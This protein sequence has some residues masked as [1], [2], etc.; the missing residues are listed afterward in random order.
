MPLLGY[1]SIGGAF[2]SNIAHDPSSITSS[3]S[4]RQAPKKPAK[5]IR[6]STACVNCRQKKIK[7]D[8]S[9]PCAHCEKLHAECVYPVAT[10]P[11][12]QEYVETL[13]N[14]LKSVESHL[15]GL[16]SRGWGKGAGGAIPGPDDDPSE[17]ND[18][19]SPYT[20]VSIPATPPSKPPSSQPSSSQAPHQESSS[21]HTHSRTHSYGHTLSQQFS[22]ASITTP[23]L[24]GTDTGS[25]TE[26]ENF[27]KDDSMEVLSLLMGSLKVERDG[28]AQYLPKIIDQQ[29]RSY[30]DSRVY[31]TSPSSFSDMAALDW[32][33]ADHPPSYT[34]PRTLLTPKAI[35]ALMDIY[36]NSVH[37]FLPVIHKTSFLTLCQEGEYRVPPFLLM[38]ICAVAARHATD[39]ELQDI[40]E[41]AN[42]KSHHALYDHARALLDT[43]MDV[44]RV[45]TVQGLLL[46]AYYQTKEKRPGHFFRIRMYVNM[47]TRMALDMGLHR[48]IRK[49]LKE[50]ESSDDTKPYSGYP[51]SFSRFGTPQSSQQQRVKEMQSQLSQEKRGVI[52]QEHRLAW[53]GCFFLDGLTSSL[54]GQEY[55]VPSTTLD[56]R[57]L[58]QEA[59]LMADTVQGAT[60]IFWY[61]HVELV[62][63]YRRISTFYRSI[64]NERA[65]GKGIRGP[66]MRAVEG[67]LDEWLANLPAHLVYVDTQVGAALPSYY[68]LYLH[69]F[70][71]SHRLLLYR[72]LI[73]NKTHRGDLKD[74][75]SP[76]AKCSQAA[77]LL[78]QIGEIIFQN[79]SWPWPGCGLFAYHMFQAAEIHL[80]QMVT[81]SAV[82]AQGLYYRTMDLIK[83]YVSLAK[84][85]DVEKDVLAME[86]M[87]GNFLLAP[88]HQQQQQQHQQPFV[89]TPASD[90]SYASVMSPGSPAE[91]I[92]R[93]TMGHM[94]HGGNGSEDADM[95][96]PLQTHAYPSFEAASRA[97][98]PQASMASTVA[99]AYMGDSNGGFSI[100]FD[101]QSIPSTSNDVPSSTLYD[102]TSLP[103]YSGP[104]SSGTTMFDS[105]NQGGFPVGSTSFSHNH[106]HQQSNLTPIG[107]LLGL[108]GS[109]F[110]HGYPNLPNLGP[111]ASSSSSNDAAKK[112]AVP[113]PKPPKRILP[114]STGSSSSSGVSQS[115]KPP[116]PK[117]P[118]RLAENTPPRWIAP[119]P[120]SSLAASTV[121]L[122]PS[123]SGPNMYYSGTGKPS[124][125]PPPAYS[126]TLSN[127][128]PSG[129]SGS[130]RHVKVLQPQQSLY[131]MGTLS[132]SL[133]VEQQ[134]HAEPP[135][136]APVSESPERYNC[137][138]GNE[139]ALQ[140]IEM[141]HH[142]YDPIPPQNRRQLI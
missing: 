40:P 126:A 70:F 112:K 67:S 117:K 109:S 51:T 88:Q 85:P 89:T 13:E 55:T 139:N 115:L 30:N 122:I 106:H 81:Q 44:P 82:D 53:L 132:N 111:G 5:R 23:N 29:E 31:G 75:N 39:F 16:L 38:A 24:T 91:S 96:S 36:F 4:V 69:R 119:R 33:S 48:S 76:M 135:P 98:R 59:T 80:F 127:G 47:A 18:A 52:H 77:G 10:K 87:V 137:Y 136:L 63:I 78:T 101:M 108:G 94:G 120:D 12:N 42:L 79:Y 118:A 125:V 49:S 7:C 105:N 43:F 1:R 71:Y 124:D 66:E 34:L 56:T 103:F 134:I 138:E 26:E 129:G 84:L 121:P 35:G 100:G 37:T 113:P 60:L 74:P 45:S 140:Y 64:P 15:Q 28:A 110:S 90:Y 2:G 116:V 83:G 62:Q 3:P 128:G 107:D 25:S 133:G 142:M 68:T 131:G 102:P 20:P 32:E 22:G 93:M 141:N 123:S 61:H 14:R 9:L 46:L 57:K 130:G 104:P 27:T 114:Q 54:L 41:L 19:S 8:G 58:I 86:E 97:F 95:F 65:L 11:A 92:A 73:S 6:I 99:P 72:P 21:S 17:D 50:I